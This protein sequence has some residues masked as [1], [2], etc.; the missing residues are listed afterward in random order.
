MKIDDLC[1]KTTAVLPLNR[2]YPDETVNLYIKDL[3]RVLDLEKEGRPR[4]SR[5]ALRD[6][7]KAEYGIDVQAATIAAHLKKL[8]KGE[9][10]WVGR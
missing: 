6:F 4:P 8:T 5:G 1:G 7:F 2:R 10:L 9:Q 3:L